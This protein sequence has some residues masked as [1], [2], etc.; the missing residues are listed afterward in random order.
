MLRTLSSTHT[1]DST[2]ISRKNF[3]VNSFMDNFHLTLLGGFPAGDA[4]NS[5]HWQLDILHHLHAAS[6]VFGVPDPISISTPPKPID[7]AMT[8]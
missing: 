1:C 5:G 2:D 3:T 4:G 8:Y 6:R 7:L